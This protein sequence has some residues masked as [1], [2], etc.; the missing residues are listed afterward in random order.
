MTISP[1]LPSTFLLK[2]VYDYSLSH[3]PFHLL[4]VP[5]A[6]SEDPNH[7]YFAG[8]SGTDAELVRTNLAEHESPVFDVVTL[9]A[10]IVANEEEARKM[11]LQAIDDDAWITKGQEP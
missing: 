6:V 5:H 10:N 1:L 2:R 4:L 11:I 9:P 7:A 8:A 3:Q